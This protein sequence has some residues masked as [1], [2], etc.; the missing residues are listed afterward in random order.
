MEDRISEYIEKANEIYFLL[1]YNSGNGYDE[2]DTL[3][4]LFHQLMSII[5]YGDTDN[6]IDYAQK[7]YNLNIPVSK[8][9]VIGTRIKTFILLYVNEVIEF[10][11]ES[12]NNEV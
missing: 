10:N 7:V 8:E 12:S 6:L 9:D 5:V 4:R 1:R 2:K 3:V 11:L